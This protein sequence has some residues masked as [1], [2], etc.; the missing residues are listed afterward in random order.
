MERVRVVFMG[1]S[2][3]VP[4]LSTV[5]SA[6]EGVGYQF[7]RGVGCRGGL[8]GACAFLG[9]REGEEQIRPG[10]A[11]QS[12][13][14]EGLHIS[15]VPSYPVIRPPHILEERTAT[16]ETVRGAYPE[17]LRCIGCNTCTR[18]CPQDIPVM[19]L[20]SATFRNDFFR[21]ADKS[22]D[23][24]LCGL[25]AAR[26]P[27]D[28]APFNI[29]LYVRRLTGRHLTPPS[30]EVARRVEAITRGDFEHELDRL[31]A[32]GKDELEAAFR[33]FQ[34]ASTRN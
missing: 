3:E 18:V 23:C 4:A 16:Y 34:A 20:L 17:L 11:C 19:D 2:Y 10:L 22:F 27:A 31:T 7:V 29:F 9:H 12:I 5:L 13:V 21:I 8:C 25:C 30:L 26:C 6:L 1:Q 24:I 33:G 32:A 14:A 15:P 28:I